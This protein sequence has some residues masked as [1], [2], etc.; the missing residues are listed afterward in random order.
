[1]FPNIKFLNNLY[2]FDQPTGQVLVPATGSGTSI[3]AD[4]PMTNNDFLYDYE[5]AHNIEYGEMPTLYFKLPAHN[6]F[7]TG[8]RIS[9]FTSHYY[10]LPPDS[11]NITGGTSNA[12]YTQKSYGIFFQDKYR[13]VHN[14]IIKAGIRLQAVGQEYFDELSPSSPEYATGHG[15]PNEGNSIYVAL[16]SGGVEYLFNKNLNVFAGAGQSFTPPRYICLQRQFDDPA[17]FLHRHFSR[18][19]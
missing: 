5:Q 15:G 9:Y 3:S 2:Y 17:V 16:P 8:A 12:L 19:S 4:Y 1:L 18:K 7:E 13:P 6:S 14:L 10:T 11:D